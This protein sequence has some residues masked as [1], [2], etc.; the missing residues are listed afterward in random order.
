MA[1]KLKSKNINAI[2]GQL[3]CHQCKAIFLETETHCIDDEGCYRY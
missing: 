1:Q 2:T 3:F